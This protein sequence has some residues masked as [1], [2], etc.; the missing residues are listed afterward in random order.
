MPNSL[1]P[2]L[3]GRR[4]TVDTALKRPTLIRDQIAKLAD[5]QILLPRFFTNLG[6]PITG[7][8]M[9]YS[10]VKASDFFTTNIEQRQPGGEYKVVE[11]VDPE[12]K[13]ATVED[14]GGKF[15]VTDE[16]RTRNDIS[17]IDQ[18][19][20][21]L[22]NTI[23]RKLDV[24][25]MAAINDQLGAENTFAGHSWDDLVFVGPETDLTPGPL[26]PSADLSA[27]QTAADLQELGVRHNLLIVHPTQAHALRSAYAE[28]LDAMLKSAGLEMFSNPRIPAG[29]AFTVESGKVGTVGFEA[30][31]TIDVW[32]DRSTRSTWVQAYAVPAFGVDRPHAAKKITGLDA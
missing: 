27:A 31:L 10:V 16:Q 17:Y 12:P 3:N 23:A 13:L 30:P 15:Q 7:G 19:T 21:Q 18:Q 6:A 8:G 20:T 11:G 25:A 22:A 26:R 4:L 5:D 14:W 1:I 32:D 29:T 24:A 28:N 9:L 2:E